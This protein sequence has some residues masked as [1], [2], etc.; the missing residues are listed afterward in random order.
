MSL[1]VIGEAL[2][3]FKVFLPERAWYHSEEDMNLW[4]YRCIEPYFDFSTDFWLVDKMEARP[5]MSVHT[6]FECVFNPLLLSSSV[7]KWN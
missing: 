3:N 6:T 7:L 1:W 5:Q 2:L 4:K